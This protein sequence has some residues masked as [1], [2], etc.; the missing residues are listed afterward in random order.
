MFQGKLVSNLQEW[1]GYAFN[2]LRPYLGLAH[3][4][5]NGPDLNSSISINGLIHGLQDCFKSTR[6]CFFKV[7]NTVAGTQSQ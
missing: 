6:K 5:H 7:L 3:P 1:R 2:F 4:H